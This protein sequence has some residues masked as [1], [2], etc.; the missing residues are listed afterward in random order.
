[1]IRLENITKGVWVQDSYRLVLD[2]ISI[3]FPEGRAIGLL[4][5]N[6][7]GK[8]T[9]LQIMAGTV[10]P[11]RGRVVRRG[12]IS[13]P[14][15]SV[16]SLHPDMTGLQNTRFLAR[17]YGVESDALTR[18]VADFAEIGAHF[19]MPLRTYSQGM[20]SRLSF[21]IAMGIPFDTYLID[22]VTGAG[23]T[24]FKRKSRHVF[25]DRMARASA[26]MVSHSMSDMRKFCDSGMVLAGGRLEFFASINA[27]IRRH[28]Q[29][30]AA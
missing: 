16:N 6:G 11:T 21:G 14:I 10:Q 20:K 5:R 24:T 23:D 12:T 26:I 15:G 19:N 4:G 7:A 1:M 2:D 30:M 9:L 3:Q 22:E 18:F 28:E 27:A 29:L 8:S 25:A 17:L 13:W